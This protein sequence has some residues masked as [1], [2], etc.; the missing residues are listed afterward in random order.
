MGDFLDDLYNNTV[1]SRSSVLSHI[2]DFSLFCHYL[3]FEPELG[4]AFHSPLRIDNNKSFAM[5]QHGDTIMYRDFATG[6]RGGI[7]KFISRMFGDIPIQEVLE[8]IN[9]DFALG[10]NGKVKKDLVIPKRVPIIRPRVKVTIRSKPFTKEG[11]AFWS[12]FYINEKLLNRYNVTEVEYVFYDGNLTHPGRLAFAYRIGTEYKIYRPY[13]IDHKFRNSYPKNYVEGYLQLERKS[14]TLIITKSLKDVMCLSA[15]GFES[16]S[17]KSESTPIQPHILAKLEADYKRI[18][19]L[20]DNDKAGAMGAMKYSHKKIFWEKSKDVSDHL[21]D[22]GIMDTR[23]ELNKM[24][25][26]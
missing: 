20:F 16:V 4:T 10:F 2:D 19:V 24:L 17:P 9:T 21:R 25:Y 8:I 1:L 12:Q 5:F 11:L 15:L 18:Y 6:D 13:S 7:F 22:Q 23:L 14:D 3:G 26:K